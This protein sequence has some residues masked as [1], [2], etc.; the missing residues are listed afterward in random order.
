VTFD[1]PSIIATAFPPPA[2]NEQW[3]ERRRAE[4]AAKQAQ[5]VEEEAAL[6][7]DHELEPAI[8][9]TRE[10]DTLATDGALEN[11]VANDIVIETALLEAEPQPASE[12]ELPTEIASGAS[13]A[14]ALQ[15]E[16]ER[17]QDSPMRK[18]R[19][20]G[21]RRRRRHGQHPGASVG[22][23]AVTAPGENPEGSVTS[24]PGSNELSP[25]SESG[26]FDANE[27]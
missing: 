3:R 11:P 4:R 22:Q 17:K 15:A 13:E 20:G 8:S 23:T 10:A 21:R 26:E 19:R 14:V 5:R 18:R 16:G 1:W 27:E 25:D 12:S 6:S 7:A 2:E 24:D 9:G